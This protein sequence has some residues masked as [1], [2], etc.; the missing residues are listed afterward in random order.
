MNSAFDNFLKDYVNLDEMEY[1][2]ARTSRNWLLD[3]IKKFP[4]NYE[5]FPKLYSSKIITFG[6]FARKTKI[7]PLDD[8]IC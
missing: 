1:L 7:K 6:S 5:D 8:L 4:K 3:Q 2:N